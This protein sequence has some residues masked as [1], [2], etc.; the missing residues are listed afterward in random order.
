MPLAVRALKA[1]ALDFIEKP[2]PGSVLIDAVLADLQSIDNALAPAAEAREIS[3]R[4][5]L[6]T[7]REREVMNALIEGRQNNEIAG[8]LGIS[9]RTV[10][11]HRAR[12]ME[13]MGARSLAALVRMAVTAGW[14]V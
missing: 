2:F 1:G 5:A 10:E 9:S 3:Q 14:E 8:T 7:A 6:L 12:V 13:K 4:T 11:I